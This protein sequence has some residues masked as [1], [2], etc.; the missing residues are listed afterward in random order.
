MQHKTTTATAERRATE[1]LIAAVTKIE[2]LK[3]VL[4]VILNRPHGAQ[5]REHVI[6]EM[7]NLQYAL[8][9]LRSYEK[10]GRHIDYL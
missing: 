6:R 2:N 5:W 9:C 7:D 10:G 1:E 3:P 8:G 4:A